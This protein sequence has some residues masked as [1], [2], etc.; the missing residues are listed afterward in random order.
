MTMRGCLGTALLLTLA[1]AH[2]VAEES[3]LDALQLADGF[4]SSTERTRD[5]SSFFEFAAGTVRQPN[6]QPDK[7]IGRVSFDL[8]YDKSLPNNWRV[9][10]SN[11]LDAG[12]D[13]QG[14]SGPAINM[15]REAYASWQASENHMLDFGR[16]NA[17]NGVATGYNPTD[18]FRAGALRSVS[19]I[20]PASLKKNRLGSVMLRGQT[21]W[22][23]GSM[24][25]LYSPKL[26]SQPNGAPFHP[27]LGATNAT[28][29]WLLSL[30]TRLSENLSPQWMLFGESHQAPQ[31]GINLT[32]L[33]NDATVLHAEWSGGRSTSL[34][35]Q[36]LDSRSDEAF[37]NRLSAGL[38]YTTE[39]KLSYTLEYQYNGA[40]MRASEWDAF[41]SGSPLDYRR[42]RN[43]VQHAQE[44]VTREALFFYGTWR[45]A[46]VNS[47]DLTAM[48]RYNVADHSRMAWLEARYHWD[49]ADL[50][51]QWQIN[52][53]SALSEFGASPQRRAIQIVAA[54]YFQ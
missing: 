11:R 25:A 51:V 12:S 13:K 7:E 33:L 31:V 54:Y 43:W 20:D 9:V 27:D 38:T 37:R 16:I 40:G 30:G 42:Y 47:L 28:H 36:A 15:L 34:R 48:V 1:A 5:L 44:L 17:R 3:E 19:S 41:R 23:G 53:G 6:G 8:R 35:S 52:S 24:T 39:S 14:R 29:R 22:D 32:H 10:L 2:A 50:A 21:L 49:K 45:D 4:S 18:Y 26:E 46:M